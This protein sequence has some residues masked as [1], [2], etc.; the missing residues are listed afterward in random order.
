MGGARPKALIDIAGEQWVIKFPAGD[1]ADVLLIEHA[2]MTLAQNAALRVARTMPVR[3][4]HGHAVAI[5]RFDRD[6]GCGCTAC[7]RAW[8]CVP[9][10]RSGARFSADARRRATGRLHPRQCAVDVAHVFSWKG[11]RR[12][13]GASRRAHRRRLEGALRTLRRGFRRCGSIRGTDRPSVPAR[14]TPP[15]RLKISAIQLP[16]FTR[17]IIDA[18][19]MVMAEVPAEFRVGGLLL[20]R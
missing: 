15:D 18:L 10:L 11:R 3:L 4:N 20:L 6:R 8:P 2:A 16:L 19:S 5:R 12:Q 7:R 13:R 14:S 9:A 1:P 17:A